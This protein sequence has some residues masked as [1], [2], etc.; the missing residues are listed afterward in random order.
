MQDQLYYR[1]P[2]T[3][4]LEVKEFSEHITSYQRYVRNPDG[5]PTLK[6]FASNSELGLLRI[7]DPVSTRVVQGFMPQTTL[8]G[9]QIFTPLKMQ[10]EAGYFPAFGKEAFV[11]PTNIK[12]EIGGKVQRL[13]TQ[14]GSVHMALSEYALGVAIENREKNEWAGSPDMLLT[15]KLN[16]VDSK[17][18]LLREY[19]QA[20][21][22]TTNGS[23]LSGLS[24]SG[25]AKKWGGATPTGD[26]VKDM[27][28]LILLVQSYNGVRPN[29]V[30]FSP[31]AWQL[32]RRNPA[33][34]DLLKYQG[35]SANPARV[36]VAG[37]ASLLEV[38]KVVIGYA[39]SGTG[40]KASGGGVGKA[41][42]T[43]SYVW[44]TVQSANAGCAIVGTA[45]GIEPAFGYTYER[46]NSPVIESYYE[47]QTKSQVWDYEHFFDAAVTLSSAGGQYYS[48]A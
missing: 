46:D 39:V 7:A 27:L 12:R 20:V 34:I 33:V 22:A 45:G 3:G 32:W 1:N 40:G 38:P 2:S 43:M 18:K 10:K 44:D 47:N 37:T 31:A 28:D 24:T 5:V 6:E 19:N 35:E 9:D 16:T 11:I 48:L 4:V 17:I 29:V 25:A 42:L 15:S 26:A 23:Y 8:I 13:Q 41:A 21:L 14:S 36:T 30:W